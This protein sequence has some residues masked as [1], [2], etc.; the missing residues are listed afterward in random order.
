M[1]T[2]ILNSRVGVV[3][4][5]TMKVILDNNKMVSKYYD[6]SELGNRNMFVQLVNT[7]YPLSKTQEYLKQLP[8]RTTQNG[9]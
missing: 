5:F 9:G 7:Y 6:L 8:V 2:T 1:E 4:K 3:I